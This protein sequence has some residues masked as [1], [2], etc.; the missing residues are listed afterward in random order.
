MR[1]WL[2][3]RSLTPSRGLNRH[4]GDQGGAGAG[5]IGAPVPICT[6]YSHSPPTPEITARALKAKDQPGRAALLTRHPEGAQERSWTLRGRPARAAGTD[7]FWSLDGMEREHPNL[8]AGIRWGWFSTS[9]L[10]FEYL[11]SQG[12]SQILRYPAPLW[13]KAENAT[14]CGRQ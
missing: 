13:G 4:L 5:G 6:E 11:R 7:V 3:A 10:M 14:A 8:T 1:G 9:E 2:G 12:V